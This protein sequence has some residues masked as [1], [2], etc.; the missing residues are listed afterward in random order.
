MGP[1]FGPGAHSPTLPSAPAAGLGSSSSPF[2]SSASSSVAV[3]GEGQNAAVFCPTRRPLLQP[4]LRPQRLRGGQRRADG[5]PRLGGL[6]ATRG[7]GPAA[8]PRRGSGG[9]EAD[10]RQPRPVAENVGEAP[11]AARPPAP[12]ALLALQPPPPPPPPLPPP[13]PPPR[14]PAAGST[15]P[16]GEGGRRVP[17]E[18]PD[19]S[20]GHCGSFA[21]AAAGSGEIVQLNVGGTR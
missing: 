4:A 3:A 5:R 6:E 18:P 17:P 8:F 12:A 20:G 14:A 15:A 16:A 11:R 9:E 19:M 13:L 7:G 1:G 21:A 10:A 2:P